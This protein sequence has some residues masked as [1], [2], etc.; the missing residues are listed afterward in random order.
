MR[1]VAPP[2]CGYFVVSLLVVLIVHIEFQHFLTKKL[3]CFFDGCFN[4]AHL[5]PDIQ[6]EQMLA[7]APPPFLFIFPFCLNLFLVKKT[8]RCS[9]PFT[10]LSLQEN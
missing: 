8:N 2:F 3:N 6:Q 5:V 7:V 9:A 1:A 4:L 10:N